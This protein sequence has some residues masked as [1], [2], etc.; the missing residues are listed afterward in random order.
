MFAVV[1]ITE[2]EKS[3]FKRFK[4]TKITSERVFLPNG[5]SFFIITAEKRGSKIPFKEILSFSGNLSDSLVFENDFTFLPQWNYTPF[6]PIKLR[7]KLLFSLAVRTLDD[8]KLN[9]F[10]TGIC[11]CDSDGIYAHD[12]QKLLKFAAKLH[13]VCENKDIYKEKQ[14]QLLSE[15]G[16]SVTLSDTFDTQG[17]NFNVVISHESHDIPLLF[18]GLIF[19]NEKRPF[20]SGRCFEVKEAQLPYEYEKLRPAGIDKLTFASALYEKCKVEL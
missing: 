5:E 20:L 3:F 18:N 1:K 13:I 15:Y 2:Q 9:P 12:V 14:K 6:A 8:L 7:K 10:E 11:L 17:K 16:V 4:K 19:T